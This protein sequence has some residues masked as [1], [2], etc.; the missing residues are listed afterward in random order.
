V[1]SSCSKSDPPNNSTYTGWAVGQAYNGF[2]TIINTQNDGF[3]WIRQQIPSLAPDVDIYDINALDYQTAWVVGGVVGGYGLILNTLD[4]GLNWTRK[5][6]VSQ[7]PNVELSA[8]YVIDQQIVWIAGKNN[9][10]LTTA[11][12]GIT[13]RS[14]ILDSTRQVNYNSITAS[15]NL[16]LWISGVPASKNPND[17]IA[18]IMHSTDGGLTWFQ[19]GLHDTLPGAV[20]CTFAVDDS[21]LFAAADG[22]VYKTTNGGNQWYPAFLKPGKKINAVCAEDINDVWAVGNNDAIYHSTNGG[23]T[24]DTITPQVKGYNLLGV[25]TN[26]PAQKIWIV[27]ANTTGKGKGI[28][29]YTNNDG[30]TWFLEDY[31][32]DA[33][34]YRVSFPVT[35]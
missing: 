35:R 17:T 22:Y 11:D 2:G 12:Q 19:Q 21:T 25:T 14:F 20:N 23:A 26:G 18:V 13:W 32:A 7:I 8:V 15:G 16:N 5:G 29:L 6:T 27:G 1:L 28:I 3:S 9:R 30:Q 10:I 33:G 4:G 31:P 24:W 34:L